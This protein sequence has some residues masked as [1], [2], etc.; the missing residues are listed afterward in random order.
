MSQESFEKLKILVVDDD[1]DL[2][3]LLTAVLEKEGFQVD[4]CQDLSGMK[5]CVRRSSYQGILLDLFLGTENGVAALPFLA[6]EAPLTQVIVMTAFGSIERA[7]EAMRLG[8]SSFISK[9]QD[10]HSIATELKQRLQPTATTLLP[11]SSHFKHIFQDIGLWGESPQMQAVFDDIIQIRASDAP[12]LI[13]GES[14]TGKELVARALHRFSPQSA[15]PFAALNCAAIP[16]NLLESEL[17]G[18]KK[19]AFTDAKA[20]R[21]GIF[22]ICSEGTLFLDEIGDMPLPLQVKI[23][24]VLQEKQIVPLG[25]SKPVPIHTRVI[26]ATLRDI[27]DEVMRGRFREDLFFRINVFM[28]YLPPLRQRQSDITLLANAFIA[29]FGERYGK[30]I[31]PLSRDIALRLEAYSWPGNVREL[32]NAIERAVV[33][34]KTDTLLI[35]DILRQRPRLKTEDGREGPSE[36]EELSGLSYAA[37]KEE[38]EKNFLVRLLKA[39]KG[40]ITEAARLSGRYRSDIYRL[41]ERHGIQPDAYK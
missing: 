24:R 36:R 19:G 31:R 20:D 38:F 13:Q 23:L 7:V 10:A 3:D 1:P 11:A 35:E 32:Q 34:A 21:K 29:S 17:F 8:A 37:A 5:E 27:E 40:S 12:V 28:I 4:T 33:L 14:G 30:S 9:S 39:S 25:A 2:R 18:H 26:T 15:G 16:E 22:E 6:A 41:L